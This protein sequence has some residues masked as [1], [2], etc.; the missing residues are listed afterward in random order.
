[1]KS[2]QRSIFRDSVWFWFAPFYAV[3]L[4]FIPSRSWLGVHVKNKVQEF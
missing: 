1:M 4:P 3:N 2:N